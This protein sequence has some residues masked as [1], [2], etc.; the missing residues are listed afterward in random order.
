MFPPIY[1]F[2]QV[3]ISII[4]WMNIHQKYWIILNVTLGKLCHNFKSTQSGLC[5]WPSSTMS[6]QDSNLMDYSSNAFRPVSKNI[7]T[8]IAKERLNN[9]A[10]RLFNFILHYY[11]CTPD[12][13][14][15]KTKSISRHWN[16]KNIVGV[17]NVQVL[18]IGNF[19]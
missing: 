14:L 11:W 15:L 16:V 10:V 1:N 4:F 9:I 6:S 8:Y 3:G 5:A 2:L 17:N 13:W 12:T 7:R 19:S 18:L